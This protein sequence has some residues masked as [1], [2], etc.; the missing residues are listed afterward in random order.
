[1]GTAGRYDSSVTRPFRILA[2]ALAAALALAVAL[3]PAL[4]AAAYVVYLKD[5]SKILAQD[6]YEVRDGKAY[7]TLPNGTETFIDASQIDVPRTEKAN[8]SNYG[9]A[10]VVEGDRVTETPPPPP[11]PQRTLGDLIQ[12]TERPGDRPAARRDPAR[13]ARPAEADRG[14]SGYPDLGSV[15]RKSFASIDTASA[16]KD[17]FRGQ[18]I[19]TV[20]IFQGTAADRPLV[21]VTAST[22]A[23][24]LRALAVATA[25]LAHLRDGGRS[26]P[27]IELYMA[28]PAHD[29]AGQFVITPD[30]AAALL[31][32]RVDVTTLYVDH[33][34]F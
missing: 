31:S 32:G 22:E 21:E 26:L 13:R 2:P 7:I 6:R 29:R 34:Q 11:P 15:P 5:G 27:A 17:F 3:L 10:V 24:V 30:M 1:M 28:T 8:R 20:E 19:D 33:V 25:A 23:S 18:G 4:P 14:A 12:E 9:T 16:L